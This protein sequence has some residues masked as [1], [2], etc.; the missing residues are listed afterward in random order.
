MKKLL[1]FAVFIALC[2][3]SFAQLEIR[4]QI[5]INSSTFTK[6]IS[7]GSLDSE[8]G[9]QFGVDLVIG[10]RFY[11]QPGIMWESLRNDLNPGGDED[12]LSFKVNRVRVPVLVG[13]KL[14]PQETGRYFNMRFFTGPN[15]SFAINKQVESNSLSFDKD[16]IKTSVFGWNAGVGLDIAVLFVDVG[17]MFGLS[18]VVK[19]LD[20]SP[21]NNLFYA[22]AGLRIRF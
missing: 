14:F 15:V 9:L 21:R 16:D 11:V 22:N 1:V 20:A 7:L 5:G 10:N 18:E 4:P 13:Y 19:D 3:A 2:Q 6:D 8:Q 17:Y 12:K